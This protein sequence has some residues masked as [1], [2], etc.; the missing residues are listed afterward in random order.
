MTTMIS[1]SRK[2]RFKKYI[3]AASKILKD[4]DR[5]KKLTNDASAYLKSLVGSN[6]KVSEV[7]DQV[8]ALVRMLK[9]QVS[10]EY[11]V[12]PW[13]SLTMISGALLYF[14]TPTDFLPDFLPIIGLTDDIAIIIWIY[15]S[16]KDDVEAFKLWEN[17]IDI[18]PI[19]E[20]KE[21]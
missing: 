11:T 12:L 10:G 7:A 19:D 6:Q 17:T 15:E 5:V 14:V 8:Y 3:Q 9:A 16:L 21:A 2:E 18:E 20:S 1:D 13:K 4:N